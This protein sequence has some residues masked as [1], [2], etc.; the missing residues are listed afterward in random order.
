MSKWPAI[1]LT[2]LG[3]SR[4]RRSMAW[5]RG[6]AS[7]RRTAVVLMRPVCH[8]SRQ[9]STLDL[10]KSWLVYI[11]EGKGKGIGMSA[12][13]ET[14]SVVRAYHR[15][16]TSGDH[17]RSVSLLAPDL[18]VEVPINNYPSAESF[19]EALRGF[20]PLVQRVEILSELVGDYQAMVLYDMDVK[21]LGTMRV[22]EHFTVSDG[23]IR[24]LRQIH[25]TAGLREA[26]FATSA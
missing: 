9:S 7:A 18:E 8:R 5:R 23:R 3:R 22:V 11:I 6:S 26:G 4:T 17:E 16:W 2:D 1:S 20:A 14:R 13:D 24:R 10:Y 21:G 12:T 25:D 15:A 19:A